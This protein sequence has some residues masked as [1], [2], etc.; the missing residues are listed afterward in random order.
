[1]GFPKGQVD[2]NGNP[3][4]STFG[5]GVIV[6]SNGVLYQQR[7]IITLDATLT[8]TDNDATGST[9]LGAVIPAPPTP[10]GSIITSAPFTA[11]TSLPVTWTADAWRRIE[12]YLKIISGSAGKVKAVFT[13]PTPTGN[14]YTRGAVNG[15]GTTWTADTTDAADFMQ[16][17][18]GGSAQ[19]YFVAEFNVKN[20][21]GYRS[22]VVDSSLVD[23]QGRYATTCFETA[24]NISGIVFTLPASSSGDLEIIGHV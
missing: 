7:N 8:A 21:G 15:G 22:G 4:P 6:D 20:D 9:T 1:M 23:S 10:V 24:T 18:T 3:I 12:V 13:G 2:R 17:S 16:W 11:Q 5:Y 14:Y 19:N